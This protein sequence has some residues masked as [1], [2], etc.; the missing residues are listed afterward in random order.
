M[1]SRYGN[2]FSS[3]LEGRREV[4]YMHD[5]ARDALPHLLDALDIERALFFGQ[6]DGASIALIFASLYPERASALIL[7]A[8]HVFVETCSIQS[9][10]A[11][12]ETF[13]ASTLR[14]R[15]R[16]HHADVDRTFFGWND[17]WLDPDFGSWRI[18]ELLPRIV[19]PALCIQGT[20]DEYGTLAQLDAI[21]RSS[22]GRV[23][24]VVLDRCGHAPHRDRP[25][26]VTGFSAQWLWELEA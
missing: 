15:M 23:D 25:E 5:E 16:K 1:Y 24:R 11:I 13:R 14:E 10:A 12:G 20:D 2:G 9:I 8:P 19:A 4:A 7:E 6:S 3:V 22:G 17:I 26:F 21:A 18:T